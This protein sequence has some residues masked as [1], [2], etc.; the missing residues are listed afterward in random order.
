MTTLFFF[1]VA[2]ASSHVSVDLRGRRLIS[3]SSPATEVRDRAPSLS[4]PLCVSFPAGFFFFFFNLDPSTRFD[5]TTLRILES[6]LVARDVESLLVS[7]AALRGLLLSEASSVMGG[8]SGM[9]V[10]KK[11]RIVQFFV[12]AFA[13]VGDGEVSLP[14]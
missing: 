8:A 7:R 4:P 13:L 3:L 5:G 12:G 14:L 11:L 10:E 9:T 6:I 1:S 2:A